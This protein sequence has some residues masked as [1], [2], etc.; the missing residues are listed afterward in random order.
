MR[1]LC[2][3]YQPWANFNQHWSCHHR[4]LWLSPL[5][6][7]LISGLLIG[8]DGGDG[9]GREEGKEGCNKGKGGL[10]LETE[11]NR[12]EATTVEGRQANTHTHT[13]TR[14][15]TSVTIPEC[16][17][18][19]RWRTGNTCLLSDSLLGPIRSVLTLLP[20]FQT[21]SCTHAHMYTL[22][23]SPRSMTDSR[24]LWGKDTP[25]LE[26]AWFCWIFFESHKIIVG[27]CGSGTI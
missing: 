27:W 21:L 9:G 5:C 8:E 11:H 16:S 13:H 10:R 24:H 3:L 20:V 19:I 15:C 18:F 4:R 23:M 7:P 1:E 17:R 26:Y 12:T 14:T 25:S 22:I 2:V 6:L